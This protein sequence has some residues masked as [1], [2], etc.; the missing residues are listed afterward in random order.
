MKETTS[1]TRPLE[2]MAA[3]FSDFFEQSMATGM[4]FLRSLSDAGTSM[5]QVMAARGTGISRMPRFPM[6]NRC[7]DVPAPCWMPV[8]LGDLTTH[9]CAGGTATLRVEV[10]NCGLSTRTIRVEAKGDLTSVTVKP[11]AFSLDSMRRGA[12][13]VSIAVPADASSG[14]E[15]EELIWIHGCRKHFLRWTVKVTRRGADCCHEIEV[16][17]CPDLVHH[18]Y[19][20][21]YCDRPCPDRNAKG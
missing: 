19:D 14:Q 10:T 20:H 13:V 1:S 15:F 9:V 3:A 8:D 2:D 18:W 11:D 7:C 17:D 21:F 5:T 16:C 4:D 6:P 12:S